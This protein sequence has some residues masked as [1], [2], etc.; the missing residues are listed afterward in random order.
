MAS[1][2]VMG[3]TLGSK[4]VS[5]AASRLAA[6]VLRNAVLSSECVALM[7]QAGFFADSAG[8]VYTLVFLCVIMRHVV[9]VGEKGRWYVH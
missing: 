9:C 8:Q 7:A 6:A 2:R 3:F 1:R 5:A 4:G